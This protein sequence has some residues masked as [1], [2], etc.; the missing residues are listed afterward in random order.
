[1]LCRRSNID[2]VIV[3]EIEA[4]HRPVRF[5]LLGL[6][7]DGQRL[8]RLPIEADDAASFGMIYLIG[9]NGSA[10][11]ARGRLLADLRQAFSKEDVVAKDHGAGA[12]AD[13][14]PADDEGLGEASRL[15][16]LGVG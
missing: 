6:L 7:L 16:L 1:R 14:L 3:V 11:P 13:K 10:A 2:D 5:R 4:G 15:G 8:A 12:V 9:E